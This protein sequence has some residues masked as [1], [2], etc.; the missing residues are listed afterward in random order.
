MDIAAATIDL[1]VHSNYSD[2]FLSPAEIVRAA[3][4]LHLYA[5]AISDHDNIL[6]YTEAM[7]E[8]QQ[9][10]IH[11]VP[12][13]ELS[14]LWQG[15][16]IHLLGYLFDP[17]N[18]AL[19]SHCQQVCDQRE[20]RAHKILKL[21]KKQG[22][23]IGIELVKQFSGPGCIGRP[24]IAQ[25]LIDEGYVF[26]FQEAFEKYLG[27]NRSAFVEEQYIEIGPAI[28]LLKDAGG[29]AVLAHPGIYQWNELL[30]YCIK[31]ELDGMEVMHPRHDFTLQNILTQ[32][33]ESK[34]LV[35]TGGS[36]F[37]GRKYYE[38]TLGTMPV[39]AIW[40]TAMLDRVQSFH[41]SVHAE[42]E[43]IF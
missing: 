42:G 18:Q 39:P 12:A 8:G 32:I 26:S 29:L 1:H 36:D 15:Q 17:N 20:Q 25:V 19:V 24:H 10:P 37:H 3:S 7:K 22:V 31:L 5:V 6:G 23:S 27:E 4:Q 11:V 16:E 13:V 34:N 35:R 9:H 43:K 30:P 38:P 14:C 2:G 28:R 41:D 21:L 33:A 40:Y